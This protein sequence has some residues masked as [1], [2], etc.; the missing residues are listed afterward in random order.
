MSSWL[1]LQE[2]SNKQGISISTLRRKIK[3]RE[4]EYI[5]KSGR[6]LLKAPAKEEDCFSKKELKDYYQKLLQE[7]DEDIKKLQSDYEDLMAL[8][9]FLEK[10]KSELL[11]CIDKQRPL[12]V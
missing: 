11:Q 9:K 10:Q 12:S 5:F 8:I 4:I 2:Y 7:R 1:T 3:G 6:Y